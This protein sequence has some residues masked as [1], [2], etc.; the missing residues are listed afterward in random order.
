MF[1]GF[2][3]LSSILLFPVAVPIWLVTVLFDRRLVL[4]HRFTCFWA[5]LYTWLN[6]LWPVT[7][8]G[9]GEHSAGDDLRARSQP[10]FLAGHPGAVPAVQDF[11]WVSK[12][13][14]FKVPLI[15]WNMSMNRYIR[16]QRGQR[17]SVVQMMKQAQQTLESGSSIMMFPEGTRSKS[18]SCSASRPARSNS[19]S[20]TGARGAD[21][22][23]SGN[24]SNAPPKTRIRAAGRHESV[25]VLALV[26]LIGTSEKQEQVRADRRAGASLAG[27]VHY[28]GQV[29]EYIYSLGAKHAKPMA[30]SVILDDVTLSLSCRGEDRRIG[31]NGAGKS[32]LFK[33][34]AGTETASNGDATGCHRL[35][36]WSASRAGPQPGR[37]AERWRTWRPR[38]A[39]TKGLMARLTRSP[40]EAPA[41]P[42]SRL[43]HAAGRDGQT[44]RKSST[45]AT[46]GISTP[47]SSRRWTRCVAHPGDADVTAL[48]GGG[49]PTGGFVRVVASPA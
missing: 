41:D 33:I 46:L 30:T 44:G 39:E 9:R 19:H 18:G 25:H 23:R 29:A 12:A 11:K 15:G 2:V 7:I 47:S 49:A 31:P 35:H 14:I 28:P 37:V 10:P 40:L 8:T 16:L 4:L 32:T 43:R 48:S 45:G 36:P 6:P 13:E 22:S 42:G 1:W 3:V 26:D 34:M 21:R 20:A 24:P 38:V 17:D 5:S 27:R